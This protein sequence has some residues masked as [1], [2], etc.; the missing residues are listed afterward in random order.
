[1]TDLNLNDVNNLNPDINDFNNLNTEQKGKLIRDWENQPSVKENKIGAYDK[2]LERPINK[3]KLGI[4]KALAILSTLSLFFIS[5]VIGLTLYSNY[6]NG[7]GLTIFPKVICAYNLTC[8]KQVCEKSNCVCGECK[9]SCGNY[10]ITPNLT[11]S[12]NI[13]LYP[14]INITN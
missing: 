13:T 11:L 9:L 5:M 2:E 6:N 14:Q 10:T 8:E 3:K 4:L 12:P 1:M 7:E